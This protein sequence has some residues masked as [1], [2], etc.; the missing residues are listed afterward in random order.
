MFAQ[1]PTYG[2]YIARFFVDHPHPNISWIHD[3][4]AGD[5]GP[6]SDCL[7]SEAE[8]APELVSKQLMLSFGKLAHLAQLHESEGSVNE[9]VLERAC[10]PY[11]CSEH[12]KFIFKLEYH[13]QLDIVSVH[14]MILRDL[15][16][17]TAPL[18]GKQSF[19][20]QIDAI[21]AQRASR[22]VDRNALLN[23]GFIVRA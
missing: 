9:A 15:K 14:E 8:N 5:Y 10:S 20:A 12:P 3:L 4:G 19:E 6:A 16:S 11:L 7:L 22:L 23:V 1:E 21:V 2:G 17:V 13:D 18:K